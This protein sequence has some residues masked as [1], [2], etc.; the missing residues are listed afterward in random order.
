MKILIL[1]G[2]FGNGHLAASQ[3]LRQQ[4]CCLPD[5]S[6]EIVDFVDYALP[7]LSGLMY[8]SFGLLVTHAGALFNLYY[9]LTSLGHPDARPPFHDLLLDRLAALL[10]EKKP[11]A[12]LATHPLCA[13]LVSLLKEETGL[14]LPLVTCITDI[15]SHPEWI[16]RHTDCYLVPTTEI[17][18]RLSARGVDPSVI[19]VTGIPVREEFRCLSRLSEKEAPAPAP[20]RGKGTRHL[21]V[22]GGGLGLLPT[23]LTFYAD[24][25]TIPDTQTTVITGQN[26]KLYQ[27]LQGRFANIQVIG[28]TS[29]VWEYM[30]QADLIVTKPGGITLF[31]TIYSQ[32]PVFTLKPSLLQERSNARWLTERGIGW[33]AGRADCAW[34]IRLLLED[35][36]LLS[37]VRTRMAHVKEQLETERLCTVLAALAQK[38][39]AA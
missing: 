20:Q 29:H 19:C 7:A 37:A 10:C 31:E 1:T 9:R 39:A 8:R 11:D 36:Q 17:R 30:A 23:D 15:S 2:R 4:L 18:D 5:T 34:E 14:S 22:M 33:T 24:L 21:L 6:A 13:Q 25:N 28:Y 26:E 35:P 38:G 32:V 27:K 16:N 12:V 3:S